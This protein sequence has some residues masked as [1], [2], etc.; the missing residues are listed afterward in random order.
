MHHVQAFM[1]SHVFAVWDFMSLLKALQRSLTCID[2]PWT[3]SPVLSRFINEIVLGEESDVNELGEAKSHFE[4]IWMP[5]INGCLY[6][7]IRLISL[8]KAGNTISYALNEID[9]D[10]RVADFV[11]FTFSIIE[12]NKPH[13]IASVSLSVERTLFQICFL[14]SSKNQL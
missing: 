2:L 13:L 9:V 6:S 5:C 10:Y 14:K 8:I 4:C 1:V 7:K 11:Q 3:A 12:T